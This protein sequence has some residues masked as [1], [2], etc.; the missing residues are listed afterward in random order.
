MNL[1]AGHIVV[2]IVLTLGFLLAI[3]V[4]QQR[5]FPQSTLAWLL[6]F[7]LLPYGAIPLFLLLGFRN[8]QTS[9]LQISSG[10]SLDLGEGK[11][12]PLEDVFAACGLPPAVSG[13]DFTLLDTPQNAH[14]AIFKIIAGAQHD[15][16]VSFYI[17]SKDEEGR[18][19]LSALTDQARTGVNVCLLLDWFGAFAAPRGALRAFRQAG[20]KLRYAAIPNLRW[21]GPG[22]NLRNHRKMIISDGVAAFAGGM[23]VGGQYMSSSTN[24][25]VWTDLSFTVSGPAINIFCAA[26]QADWSSAKI[27]TDTLSQPVAKQAKTGTARLQLVPSGP[28]IDGDVLH[29]SLVHAIHCAHNRIWLASPYYLPSD[30]LSEALSLACRRGVDVIII[31]PAKSN[32][33]LADLARGPYLR[34]VQRRGGNI[35]LHPGMLHAKMGVIDDT[36]WIGS[37]NFD[38][39]SMFLNSELALFVSDADSVR[40]LTT[41]FEQEAARCQT[42]T[43]TPT[44]FQKFL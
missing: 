15:L 20:R 38:M 11:Q 37:A 23:N 33:R 40:R 22:L 3:I 9:G 39:R 43:S 21:H 6:A 34:E 8:K 44:L 35:L 30:T 26:F 10:G 31:T 18:A 2:V 25:D 13:N 29:D 16:W 41:W 27:D 5:R 7:F 36:A 12:S 32:Q 17:I 28:G 42:M 4:T 1:F 24:T 19:F 14:R